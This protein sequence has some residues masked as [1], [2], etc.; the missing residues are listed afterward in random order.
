MAQQVTSAQLSTTL[1]NAF[2]AAHSTTYTGMVHNDGP[3]WSNAATPLEQLVYPAS[4]TTITEAFAFLSAAKTFWNAHLTYADV[5]TTDHIFAHKVA[6]GANVLT[7]AVFDYATFTSTARVAI[8]TLLNDL[9]TQY[10][11]H[12]Q[13]TGGS[14]HAAVDSV[15]YVGVPLTITGSATDQEIV[16][17][18]N[19]LK[20]VVNDH[21]V[22]TAGG[23]HSSADTGDVSTSPSATSTTTMDYAAVIVL[24][25]DLR[26]T[27]IAHMG[28]AT[29]HAA[30][31]TVNLVTAPA[32]TV[33]AGFNT[34]INEMISKYP[35]HIAST[36]YHNVADT[37]NTLTASSVS[38]LGQVLAAAQ[39]LYTQMQGHVREA[40]NDRAFRLI[41]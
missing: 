1:I 24:I 23:V 16:E 7:S 6:D 26:T 30:A 10:D 21:V 38:S 37:T 9:Y 32:P 31:D 12:R 25:T 15:N 40:S 5:A 35:T 22:N 18:L 8:V 33:T 14:W 3:E 27:L 2:N 17:R 4:P 29:Y 19:L 36:T 20:S 28:S 39:D 41:A 11:A 34:L 13:N